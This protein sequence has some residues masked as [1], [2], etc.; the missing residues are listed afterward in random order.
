MDNFYLGKG[1]PRV[2]GNTWLLKES[3]AT[4][5]DLPAASLIGTSRIPGG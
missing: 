5:R 3:D 2:I 4:G 1:V